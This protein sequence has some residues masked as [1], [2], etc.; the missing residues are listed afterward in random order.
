MLIAESENKGTKP[1]KGQSV[2]TVTKADLIE[3]IYEKSAKGRSEVKDYVEDLI[4]LINR[5]ITAKY[6][7]LIS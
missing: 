3:A 7:V 1:L 6:G 2:R 4:Y 5:A